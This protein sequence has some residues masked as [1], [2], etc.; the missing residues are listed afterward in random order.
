M[1]AQPPNVIV[2]THADD[3]ALR[4]LTVSGA[5]APV[6]VSAATLD[7]LRTLYRGDARSESDFLQRAAALLLRSSAT[8]AAAGATSPDSTSAICYDAE[9]TYRI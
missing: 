7:K 1:R 9:H 5:Q 8:A 6:V 2:E 4:R 3:A